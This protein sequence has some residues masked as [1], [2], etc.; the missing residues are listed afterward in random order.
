M[1]NNNEPRRKC[2][3]DFVFVD[4]TF[5]SVT[6]VAYWLTGRKVLST[7][8]WVFTRWNE[9][10]WLNFQE[11]KFGYRL[12]GADPEDKVVGDL[13][14]LKN[15]VAKSLVRK[16]MREGQEELPGKGTATGLGGEEKAGGRLRR[17]WRG[18]QGRLGERLDV[19]NHLLN[20]EEVKRLSGHLQSLFSM[21]EDLDFR[22]N[23]AAGCPTDKL[24]QRKPP[25][26]VEPTEGVTQSLNMDTNCHSQNMASHFEKKKF[27]NMGGMTPTSQNQVNLLN[28]LALDLGVQDSSGKDFI[29]ES[30]HVKHNYNS[31]LNKL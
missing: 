13:A 19:E 1:D 14:S 18:K 22:L 21:Y 20:G 27:A 2:N 29:I 11:V 31:N 17:W 16:G 7:L 24:S 10:C 26:K 15:A 12:M 23:H 9:E 3:A 4:R 30:A 8:L 6:D 28:T 25:L 5:C